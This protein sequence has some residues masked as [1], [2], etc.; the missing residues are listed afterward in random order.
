[1]IATA[2]AGLV[3]LI[4]A[5]G[6]SAVMLETSVV[7]SDILS[8]QDLD[9]GAADDH[10]AAL[11]V[12]TQ[13]CIDIDDPDWKTLCAAAQSTDPAA[14]RVFFE[15]L[16]QDGADPMFTGYFEP[17]LRGARYPT[18]EF[19][20]ALYEL[21]P[22]A[23]E[24]QSWLDR[25]AILISGLMDNRGLEIAWVDDHLEFFFLQIQGFGGIALPDGQSLR[26]GYGGA[27]GHPYRSISVELVRQGIYQVH[28]V[29]AQVIQNCV[30][31]FHN[32]SYMFFRELRHLNGHLGLLRE[33]N[34]PITPLMTIAVDL[35]YIPLGA[36][37]WIEKDG[38]GPMRRV[39]IAQDTG[40]A[41]K[42]AQRADVFFGTGDATGRA[43][44]RLRDSGRMVVLLSI[45]C[46][47]TMLP[48]EDA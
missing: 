25:Y 18:V 39:M 7:T 38:E 4:S 8:F 43:A 27:D 17:E 44:G 6:A 26:V 11:D 21:P 14:A 9:G 29:S 32:P 23:Q 46:A 35:A 10:A 45:R 30:L 33:M 19:C 48:K 2:W 34:R 13:P 15:L 5:L 47:Y 28:Q 24:S 41:T 3:A 22:E 31:L 42:G 37:V 12:F 20:Y 16:F 36:T 40:S 1:M